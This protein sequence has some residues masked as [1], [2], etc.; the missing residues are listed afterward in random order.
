M[1]HKMWNLDLICSG[2]RIPEMPSSWRKAWDW[3]LATCLPLV[4]LEQVLFDVVP[5]WLANFPISLLQMFG[6]IS[7]QGV[8][9]TSY[10]L[11]LLFVKLDRF[12]RE[13][14]IFY[15]FIKLSSFFE[16][17][18]HIYL[19]CEMKQKGL[20]NWTRES[21]TA[22]SFLQRPESKEWVGKTGSLRW[23]LLRDVIMVNPLKCH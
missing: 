18:I 7:T 16:T 3:V 19:G 13:K 4:W 23:E 17:V 2:A 22:R 20:R 1:H 11:R 9:F 5:S 12:M 8:N 10:F 6:A 15:A 21:C 14:K